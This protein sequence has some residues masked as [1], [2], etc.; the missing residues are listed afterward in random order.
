[1]TLRS[2]GP[3][4]FLDRDGTL[5]RDVNYLSSID[6]IEIFPGVAEALRRLRDCGFKLVM[7]TNQSGVARGLLS[8][9]DVQM[10]HAE[11]LSRLAQEHATLD[12]IYYCPHHPTEGRELYRTECDCRKP[13]PGMIR[14]AVAELEIDPEISY[15]VGDQASDLELAE[16]VG[17]T[18]ILIGQGVA[19]QTRASPVVIAED[20][21]AAARWIMAHSSAEK[22]MGKS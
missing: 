11:I 19:A 18:G 17:A 4:V 21:V 10:I 7:V 2:Q 15:V 14:R 3:A 16:S 5:I 1:M 20:L 13:R 8:E 6:Q 9:A 12:A 22:K